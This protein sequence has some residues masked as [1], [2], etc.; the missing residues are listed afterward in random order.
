MWYFNKTLVNALRTYLV[1]TEQ[2]TIPT[3]KNNLIWCAGRASAYDAWCIN[4]SYVNHSYTATYVRFGVV[5]A[6][7]L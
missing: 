2:W 5:G 6:S 7:G 3:L 4:P 1:N